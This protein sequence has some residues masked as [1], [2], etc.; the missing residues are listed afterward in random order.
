VDV[1]FAL[2]MLVLVIAFLLAIG[3][4]RTLGQEREIFLQQPRADFTMR[5]AVLQKNIREV[6]TLDGVAAV[7]QGVTDHS[8]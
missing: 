2:A 1:I 3:D 5:T 4:L 6:D 7:D 8:T